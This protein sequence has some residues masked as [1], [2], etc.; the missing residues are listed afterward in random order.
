MPQPTKSDVHVNRPLT[1]ISIAYLQDQKE[2]VTHKI[3][4]NVPV[5][6]QSDAYFTYDKGDWF[7]TEA[8]KRA[9]GTESAGS[10]YGL[11]TDS[12][13]CDVYALHKDVDDQIR[14]NS[15]APL[16]PDAEASE[17]VTRGLML[18][19]E[20][21]WVDTFF[22]TSVWTGAA[23]FTP[24]T[25]WSASGSTPIADI[26]SKIGAVK[27]KTGFRPNTFSMAEDVWLILQDNA[28]FLDRISVNQRKIVTTDLLAA[29]LG[30]DNVYIL[31]GVENSAKE[32]ATDDIDWI[33]SKHALL[34]YAPARPSLMTPS[35]GY[36]FSWIGYLGAGADGLRTLRFRMPHLRADRI[37]GEMAYDQKLVGADLGVFFN[38]VIA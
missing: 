14:A 13:L 24:S 37:E 6:K 17:F 29:V 34:S 12:Y 35:A 19:R 31:G 25:L 36:T 27:A 20:K 10:G 21:D 5:M 22:T 18:R 23:D 16:S 11:D 32:G 15:D 30:I 1:N 3:F 28:D 4:P 9:P 33:V 7:R 8:R 2:F 26:R 38:G